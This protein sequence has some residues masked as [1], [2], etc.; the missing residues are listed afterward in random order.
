MN[1]NSICPVQRIEDIKFML[2]FNEESKN[3]LTVYR[4][5]GLPDKASPLQLSPP[6]RTLGSHVKSS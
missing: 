4:T 1:S 5:L 2:F 3:V 6:L